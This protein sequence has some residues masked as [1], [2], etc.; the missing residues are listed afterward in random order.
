MK[1]IFKNSAFSLLEMVVAMTIFS[2][3]AM[4]LYSLFDV[5]AVSQTES[6]GV[7]NFKN[8]G[9][10]II[11][12][13]AEELSNI[14]NTDY[15]I[16]PV[17]VIDTT[18]SVKTKVNFQFNAFECGN[19][20]SLEFAAAKPD[21]FQMHFCVIDYNTPST[22]EIEDYIKYGKNR[23]F[24]ENTT[25]KEKVI[26][27]NTSNELKMGVKKEKT[28][29]GENNDVDGVPDKTGTFLTE[30]LGKNVESIKYFFWD[31][32]IDWS[33]DNATASPITEWDSTS[34]GRLPK[35]IK[36]ILTM[37]YN[38]LMYHKKY[39]DMSASEKLKDKL[40]VFEKV[41]F[42]NERSF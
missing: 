28:K 27:L 1:K 15:Y 35:A 40:F 21:S 25:I 39:S 38:P 33:N 42:L 6:L 22:T 32:N 14:I 3:I 10:Q 19:G 34:L 26:F 4:S 37:R 17:G 29:T 2:I 18:T 13:L 9:Y 30:S 20:N 12:T 5:L 16:Y 41:I 36:I 23:I 7:N 31:D 24:W 8:Q 11:E